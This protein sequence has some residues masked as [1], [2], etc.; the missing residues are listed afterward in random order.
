[1]ISCFVCKN[2]RFAVLCMGGCGLLT[3]VLDAKIATY[4]QCLKRL[5]YYYYY[6]YYYC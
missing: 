2:A 6:Y 1:M 3:S 4:H 5:C